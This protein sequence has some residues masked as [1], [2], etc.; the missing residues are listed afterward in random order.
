MKSKFAR[1]RLAVF[2][3]LACIFSTQFADGAVSYRIFRLTW[4]A[5]TENED[6]SPL[7]DLQGYY[8]YSGPSPETLVPLIFAGVGRSSIELRY[9]AVGTYCFGV[10]AVNIRGVESALTGTVSI[11]PE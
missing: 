11:R 4:A 10:T 1:L 3:S 6:G 7:E 9:P 2:V 5:P 8:I